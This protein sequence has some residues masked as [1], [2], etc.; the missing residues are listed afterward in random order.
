M[1]EH[2]ISVH[3][4][5]PVDVQAADLV[6]EVTSDGEKLGELRVSRGSIDWAPRAHH[7]PYWLEWE[8]FDE[9]MRENGRQS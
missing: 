7:K 8:R 9:I 4:S 6:V 1:P 3:I 2:R 5:K